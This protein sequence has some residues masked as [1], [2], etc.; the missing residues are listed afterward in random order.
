MKNTYKFALASL[1]V[2][3]ALSAQA[4]I[5]TEN[6]LGKFSVSGD[7]E[8]DIDFTDK[9][10]TDKQEFK[11]GG[12]VLV[13]FA[14]EHN[15][16]GDRYIGMQAQPLLKTNGDVDLDDAWFAMGKKSGLATQGWAF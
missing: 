5:T 1:L 3:A 13:Q 9:N 4:G 6:E 11:Q 14:A 16:S 10:K 2:S 8:F 15:V 7:V 12:R